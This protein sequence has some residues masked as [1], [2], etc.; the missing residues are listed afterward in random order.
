MTDVVD[1]DIPAQFEYL[2]YKTISDQLI[3]VREDR[4]LKEEKIH[5][6]GKD[7]LQNLIY[8]LEKKPVLCLSNN[9]NYANELTDLLYEEFNFQDFFVLG[10]DCRLEKNQKQNI[11]PWPFALMLQQMSRR[12]YSKNFQKKFRISVLSRH[13]RA[14]R[15]ELLQAIRPLVTNMDV[16]VANRFQENIPCE[17]SNSD[18]LKQIFDTLPWTNNK[19]FID[20]E[21]PHITYT[22]ID[23]PAW[24]A[25]VNV[26]NESWHKNDLCFVTEKTW[27]A[28][29]NKCLVIN[30]GSSMMPTQLEQFGLEIWK[31]FDQSVDYK[32]KINMVVDLFQNNNVFEIYKDNKDLIDHNYHLVT[33]V[34]FARK[35][36]LPTIEKIQ[37]LFKL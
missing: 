3:F 25:C 21:T 17:V 22:E 4:L 8:K 32:E 34:E 31:P 27:K 36:A 35:L 9:P 30:Y 15:L 20:L 13:A 14:H 28:Y 6:S 12:D 23:H 18:Q 33:S 10:D 16:V 37:K 1:Y 29:A 5:Q 19:K 11:G 7:L 24:Q 26:T 2:G